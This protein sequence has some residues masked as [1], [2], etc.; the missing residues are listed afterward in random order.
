MQIEGKN[1][2]YEYYRSGNNIKKVLMDRNYSDNKKDEM[3]KFFRERKIVLEIVEKNILEKMSKTGKHQGIIFLVP[4][5]EYF[6]FDEM[7]SDLTSSAKENE[8]IIIC[9]SIEDPHNLGSIIRTAECVGAR[10]VIISKN[11]SAQVNET[12]V[13]TS[14]GA[15]SH[16]DVCR[17]SNINDAIRKLK[18]SG[19]FVYGLEADG[20]NMSRTNLTGKTAIV[21]GSE[22][23]GLSKLTRELCD[24]VI[25]I[26]M[27]GK[28]NSLNA[29]IAS[30]V[31]MYEYVAQCKRKK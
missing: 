16:L 25:S 1:A 28:V 17:V 2:C 23:F 12:V 3:M 4:E 20:Q 26:D 27:F 6:D 29:S 7:V 30:A 19:V 13:K 9:D 8:L 22:G 10:G 11:R 31:I 5:Y 18:S 14:A 15:A 21:V 24:D